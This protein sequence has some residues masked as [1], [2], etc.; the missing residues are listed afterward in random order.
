[1]VEVNYC[2]GFEDDEWDFCI[3]VSIL[4]KMGFFLVR[5]LMNN[6]CKIVMMENEGIKVIECVEFKV[7]ENCFNF[8]YFVIK[9]VK[10]GYF[11]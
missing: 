3:G 1:M 9:V 6:L 10:F 8:V 4:K 11:L 5:L 7:G 2:F